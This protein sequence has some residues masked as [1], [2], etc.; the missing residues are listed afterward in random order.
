MKVSIIHGEAEF[1]AQS[2]D[3]FQ[4]INTGG[5]DEEHWCSR[6][7]FLVRFRELNGSVL[8]VFVTKFLFDK[9]PGNGERNR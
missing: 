2:F 8:D 9:I 3:I 4:W 6:T 5:E 1:L 7:C